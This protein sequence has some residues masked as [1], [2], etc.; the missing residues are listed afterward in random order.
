MEEPDFG[1]AAAGA[2]EIAGK[3]GATPTGADRP[4]TKPTMGVEPKQPQGPQE[5][6][7][8]RLMKAKKRV[9]EDREKG[10]EENTS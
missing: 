10:K 6:Y 5:S 7:T 2:A 4:T 3:P 9:W 8:D 1:D